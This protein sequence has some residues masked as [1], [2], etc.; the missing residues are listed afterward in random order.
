[1]KEKNEFFGEPRNN[2][3]EIEEYDDI[4]NAYEYENEAFEAT[5]F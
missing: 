4:T 2:V 5:K 1:M 3:K